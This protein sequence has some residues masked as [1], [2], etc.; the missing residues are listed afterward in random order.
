MTTTCCY[1]AR[2]SVSRRQA[3]PTLAAEARRLALA[4]VAD[5]RALDAGLVDAVL[6][7]AA[8]TGDA[9]L[10]DAL[11]AEARTTGDRLDRRNLVVALMSFRDPVLAERGLKLLLDPAFD[12]RELNEALRTSERIGQPRRDV[13]E[14]IK[15]NFDAFSRRVQRDSPGAWPS[16]AERLCSDADRADVEAFWRERIAGYAGGARTLTQALES[17]ELCTRLRAAQGGSVAA[18]LKRYN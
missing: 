11:L 13:H 18:F 8:W 10:F 6:P 16:Y 1:V 5:R 9:A 15:T 14:F 3:I 17:I 7:V 4:W 12:M 2:C